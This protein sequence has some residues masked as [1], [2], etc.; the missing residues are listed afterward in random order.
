MQ[1]KMTGERMRD[2]VGFALIVRGIIV[3]FCL[4][5]LSEAVQAEE[6]S[7]QFKGITLN[8]NL[9][10]AQDKS[11]TDGVILIT[12]G[13]LAHNG[14][15]IVSTLQQLIKGKG[16]NTIAI[17]LSLGIDNRHGM[18]DCAVPHTHKHEDAV[19]E[20]G[21]WLHWLKKKGVKKVIL[22]GHSRGGNQIAR[23]ASEQDDPAIK[24][25][26]LIAP[27]T[28]DEDSLSIN[29]RQ[30]YK[31]ELQ[32]IL[33][34]AGDLVDAG[35]GGTMLTHTD[36]LYCENASVTAEAFASYYAHDKKMDTPFLL[37][38]IKKPVLVIAAG[39]DNIVPDLEK[40]ISPK[41]DG[42]KIQLVV[43][44][45]ADH[46]FRDLSAEDLVDA[47]TDFLKDKD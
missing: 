38:S 14:M 1:E 18:Y 31:K 10:Q 12:H 26:I 37:P 33:K 5:W 24:G 36:F 20:I 46:F 9:E 22:M 27:Q 47:I 2:I 17:N 25:V 13:T 44:E 28:W 11:I 30:R 7:I 4:F 34:K 19:A 41:A 16:W 15:E 21:A 6:V 32:P 3:I 39:K 23:F 42:K 8:A 40:K 35:K 45:M 29:Y 43:V